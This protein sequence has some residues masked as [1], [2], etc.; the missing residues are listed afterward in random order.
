MT[1]INSNLYYHSKQQ[2][3][4]DRRT[5]EFIVERCMPFMKGADV[6]DMGYV[7]EMWTD[8]II[9][10]G[11]RS[12]IVEGSES[13]IAHARERFEENNDVTIHHAMFEDFTPDRLYNTI[14]AGDILRYITE[15]VIFLDRLRTWLVPGG[16][17]IVTIPNSKSLHRRIGSLLNMESHPDE[18]NKRDIEVGN[19]RSYDRYSLRHEILQ[20]GLNIQ[21]IRG[22]FLKPL[23]SLQIESWDNA[24]LRAFL[25]I[26]DELEDYAWFI[27]AICENRR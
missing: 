5:K 24:L 8:A 25:E 18:A 4:V 27:Y 19:L 17:L 11:W 6:L 3:G 16:R 1:E 22:C 23:S 10:Q 13:H 9:R 14:I 7:D 26:G 12:H 15:P 21:E 20:A 2:K